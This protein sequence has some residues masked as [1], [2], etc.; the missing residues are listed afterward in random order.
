MKEMDLLENRLRSWRPRRPSA[1]LERRLFAA[2]FDLMP[3]M[4]WLFGSLV[5]AAACLLLTFSI[6]NSGNPG[7]SMRHEPM[8]GMILS[9]QNYAAYASDNFRNGQNNL[10]GVTFEWTNHNVSPSSMSPF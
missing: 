10:S 5:P 2:P 6:F 7:I 8:V 3:K 9:N 4:A 1:A